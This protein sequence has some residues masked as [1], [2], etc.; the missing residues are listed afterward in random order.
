MVNISNRCIKIL[1]ILLEKNDYINIADIAK[2]CNASKR[3]IRYDLNQLKGWLKDNKIQIHSLPKKG[4]IIDDNDRQKVSELIEETQKDNDYFF[5]SNERTNLLISYLLC[6]YQG[7]TLDQIANK[8]NI[9]KNTLLRD[10]DKVEEWFFVHGV[11]L[12]RR[13][14][15][16]IVLEGNETEKRRLIV[17]YLI[18]NSSNEYFFKTYLNNFDEQKR[19]EDMLNSK[20]SIFT[21]LYESIDFNII[22][23]RI[24]KFYKQFSVNIEDEN[25]FYLAH[26]LA[27][28]EM[29]IK[30][31]HYLNMLPKEYNNY[32]NSL[33]FSLAKASDMCSAI[34]RIENALVQRNET[35]YMVSLLFGYSDMSI[36]NQ[37][38]KNDLTAENIYNYIVERILDM[39]RCDISNDKDLKKGLQLHLVSMITRMKLNIPYRNVMLDDIKA[40]FSST[41][42]MCVVIFEELCQKYNFIY[43]ENEIGFVVLYVNQAI[44]RIRQQ[45]DNFHN[46]RIVLICGQGKAT[47]VFLVRNIEKQFPNLEIVDKLSVFNAKDYDFSNID[48]ILTTVDLHFKILKP[49]IKVYPMLSKRDVIKIDTFLR[50]DN[51]FTNH[52]YHTD[53]ISNELLNLI[54]KN[55][56]VIDL[57]Q[58]KIDLDT[59]LTQKV[60]ENMYSEHI[61]SL[62]EVMA[63]PYIKAQIDAYDWE[64]AVVQAAEPLIEAKKIT[65]RYLDEI[66]SL[67]DEIHQYA[68]I[69]K[70]IC[71]PHASPNSEN[72]LAMSLATLKTPIYIEIDEQKEEIKVIIVL[73]INNSISYAK[74]LDEIFTMFE[75]YPN[76]ADFLSH[77]ETDEELVDK[78]KGCYDNIK[79]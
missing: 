33:V 40:N 69:A 11:S 56:N 14:K 12:K 27:V 5:S 16:G 17:E 66:F 65:P 25:F 23:K 79:W 74:A 54:K 32:H 64:D 72:G 10:L 63:I 29:R 26:F 37:K 18:E 75:E 52:N 13:Q 36:K 39:S 55:C 3:T 78:I 7:E 41:F 1:K 46:A 70:G 4:I 50:K 67:K 49:I 57:V 6:H 71:M 42:K 53:I 44:E 73:T 68:L 34:N 45:Y 61:P 21:V 2:F 62:M 51:K 15:K 9:S 43:D 8:F 48:L 58:L 20:I 38:S 19:N 59:Y 76:L 24:E 77:A 60:N 30:D 31:E 28:Q 35:L 22:I 47:V